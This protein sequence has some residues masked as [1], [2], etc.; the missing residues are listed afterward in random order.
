MAQLLKASMK[1]KLVERLFFLFCTG[2]A[3]YGIRQVTVTVRIG[4]EH[5]NEVM[6]LS[7][8]N[9]DPITLLFELQVSQ[10]NFLPLP[11]HWGY[12]CGVERAM[13]MDVERPTMI[14]HLWQIAERAVTH[15][16]ADM[17]MIVEQE[18]AEPKWHD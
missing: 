11:E 5:G 18:K 9:L 4:D 16:A 12:K 10:T 1:A 6:A 7:V 2:V 8:S 15:Y 13:L 3:Q 17:E 14:N